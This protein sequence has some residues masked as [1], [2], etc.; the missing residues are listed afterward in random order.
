[1][2]LFLSLSVSTPV[3]PSDDLLPKRTVLG[4]HALVFLAD[5][6]KIALSPAVSPTNG[7]LQKR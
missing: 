3:V 2:L 4:Q 1:M 6:E 7:T 5:G